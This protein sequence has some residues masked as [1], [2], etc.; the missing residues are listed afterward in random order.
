VF[1]IDGLQ[2][3]LP[4]HKVR[5]YEEWFVPM[6]P[7]DEYYSEAHWSPELGRGEAALRVFETLGISSNDAV[8]IHS[9]GVSGNHRVLL[10]EMHSGWFWRA[11]TGE[12]VVLAE[13]TKGSKP[14][15]FTYTKLAGRERMRPDIFPGLATFDNTTAT[16]TGTIDLTG[17]C[18]ETALGNEYLAEAASMEFQPFYFTDASGNKTLDP[19]QVDQVIDELGIAALTGKIVFRDPTFG[20]MFPELNND[21]IWAT[22]SS[23]NH[24]GPRLNET[25]DEYGQCTTE[26]PNNP[27]DLDVWVHYLF[28]AD[29]LL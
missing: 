24:V 15:E 18:R 26:L 11:Y 8:G 13:L 21:N 2:N 3:Y 25:C 5:A 20:G 12:D 4:Y 23:L 22:M 7:T 1:A 29:D 14:C 17:L 10:S 19:E 9:I 16:G 27:S 28:W 6:A